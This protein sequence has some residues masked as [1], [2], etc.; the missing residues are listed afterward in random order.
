MNFERQMEEV[1]A[2]KAVFP[3]PGAVVIDDLVTKDGIQSSCISGKILLLDTLIDD[4]PIG[5]SFVLPAEYP[6]TSPDV[7]VI[8]EGGTFPFLPN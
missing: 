3:E 1:E 6:D 8:C 2:I 4:R 7:Q 5:I